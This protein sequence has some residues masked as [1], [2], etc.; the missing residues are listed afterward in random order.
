HKAWIIADL[1]TKE[2]AMRIVPL[3]YRKQAKIVRLE[4]FSMDDYDKKLAVHHE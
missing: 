1:E 2:E 4:K 3:E